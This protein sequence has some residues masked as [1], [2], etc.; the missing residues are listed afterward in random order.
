ML[1]NFVYPLRKRLKWF[2]GKGTIVPGCA[3]TSSSGS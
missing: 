2:K 1:L 3:F